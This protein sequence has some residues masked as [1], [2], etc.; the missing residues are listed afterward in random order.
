MAGIHCVFD[1][2]EEGPVF[3]RWGAGRDGGGIVGAAVPDAE[4]AD[5]PDGGGDGLVEVLGLVDIPVS[6][7]VDDVLGGHGVD[8]VGGDAGVADV[9]D[10]GAEV[11]GGYDELDQRGGVGER[12]VLVGETGS[13]V[14]EWAIVAGDVGGVASDVCQPMFEGVDVSIAGAW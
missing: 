10:G 9:V 6:G 7:E 1:L 3:L 8:V 4:S 12:L 2:G 13:E 11:C 5:L 14:G